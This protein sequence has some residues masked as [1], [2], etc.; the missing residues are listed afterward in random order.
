MVSCFGALIVS[1]LIFICIS[2]VLVLAD[3]HC[4]HRVAAILWQGR[5]FVLVCVFSA[6]YCVLVYRFFGTTGVDCVFTVVFMYCGGHFVASG[7]HF[8]IVVFLF[9][10]VWV[11]VVDRR[12]VIGRSALDHGRPPSMRRLLGRRLCRMRRLLGRRLA[13]CAGSGGR[14]LWGWRR[15]V[16]RRQGNAECAAC[17]GGNVGNSLKWFVFN[18]FVLNM[19]M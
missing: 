16:G 2:I 15:H 10:H 18:L 6:V 4:F 5:H 3:F 11:P 8:V 7:R 1:G 17:G 13:E 9:V 14:R 12:R 19:C